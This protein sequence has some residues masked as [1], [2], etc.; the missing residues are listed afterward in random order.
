MIGLNLRWKSKVNKWLSLLEMGKETWKLKKKKETI[1]S[2]RKKALMGHEKLELI[3]KTS[4]HLN[5]IHHISMYIHQ[6]LPVVFLS[7]L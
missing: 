7:I 6:M 1:E 5:Y 2:W 4:N 3:I